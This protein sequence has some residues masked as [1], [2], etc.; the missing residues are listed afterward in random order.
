VSATTG[1]AGGASLY[2]FSS[3]APPFMPGEGYSKSAAYAL[4]EHGG[5]FSA[6]A[7]EL[8]RSGAGASR[9][10]SQEQRVWRGA[11]G[12]RR[13]RFVARYGVPSRAGVP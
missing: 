5:D 4:L 13:R 2:V 7:R 10:H 1:Y 9:E 11:D 8:A 12:L 3:N 6:A